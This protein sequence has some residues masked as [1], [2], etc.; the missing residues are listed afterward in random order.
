MGNY[1][2]NNNDLI[3][4][5]LGAMFLCPIY[6]DYDDSLSSPPFWAVYEDSDLN[7]DTQYDGNYNLNDFGYSEDYV[8]IDTFN[9]Y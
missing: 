2:I 1:D 6:V 5:N 8:S 4:Y 7:Y 9:P 3:N